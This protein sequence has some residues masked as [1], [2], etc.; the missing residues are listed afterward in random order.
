MTSNADSALCNQKVDEF[1]KA[2]QQEQS[3]FKDL[4]D[5]T[6]QECEKLLNDN[7]IKGIVSS[8]SKQLVSLKKKLDDMVKTSEITNWITGVGSDPAS[9]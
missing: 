8:R 2:F 6:R 9:G 7:N 5:A 4:A 3:L 1:L